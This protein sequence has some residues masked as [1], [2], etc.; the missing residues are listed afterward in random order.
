MTL[1]I[2]GIT[3]LDNKQKTKKKKPCLS[4][5]SHK[6]A[7]LKICCMICNDV[8]ICPLTIIGV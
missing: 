5:P 8:M 7:P 4:T 2:P 3:T 6:N 1:K